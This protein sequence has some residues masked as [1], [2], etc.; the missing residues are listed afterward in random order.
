MYS[1]FKFPLLSHCFAAL[2]ITDYQEA[3]AANSFCMVHIHFYPTDTIPPDL[4][5]GSAA[6]AAYTRATVRC[7]SRQQG[8][9]RLGEWWHSVMLFT[10]SMADVDNTCS[11]DN[12]HHPWLRAYSPGRGRS[13]SPSKFEDPKCEFVLQKHGLVSRRARPC[14][15]WGQYQVEHYQTHSEPIEQIWHSEAPSN[16]FDRHRKVI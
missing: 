6:Y 10:F 8:E 2:R 9:S 5:L 3:R 12:E 14:S 4:L 16:Y 13:T 15:S 11:N 1:L 7:S